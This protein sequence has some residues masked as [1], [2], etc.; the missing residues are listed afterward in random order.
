MSS[1]ARSAQRLSVLALLA[2]VAAMTAT[3]GGKESTSPPVPVA[4]EKLS[5]D[6][7]SGAAHEALGQPLVVKVL[8]ASGAGV[9][10]VRVVWVTAYPGGSDLD[11]TTTGQTG[12]AQLAV[13]LD[14]VVG[15]YT[16]TASAAQLSPVTFTITCTPGPAAKLV[17]L[18]QPSNVGALAAISPAVQ[19][20]VRDQWGNPVS[21]GAFPVQIWITSGTGA[22]GAT[23]SGSNIKSTAQG[24]VSYTDLSIDKP[25]TGYTLTALSAGLAGAWSSAFNVTPFP[26]APH[27]TFVAQP[28]T[29]KAGGVIAPAIQ[30]A[31]QGPYG[32]TDTTS[33]LT[34]TLA[35]TPGAGSAGARL[36]GTVSSAAVRGVAG[37][38]GLSVSYMGRGYTLTATASGASPAVSASFDVTGTATAIAMGVDHSCILASDGRVFCYGRNTYGQIGSANYSAIAAVVILGGP[39]AGLALGENHTCALVSGGA[40]SCWGSSVSG[41]L[42]DGTFSGWR[43]TPA[44]VSGGLAFGALD[45]T[46]H[47]TCGLTLAGQAWCWGENGS[48]QIGAGDS[49]ERDVPAAVSGGLTLSEI[50]V[51][52]Y[53]VCG[54]A[55]GGQAYCWGDNTSGEVGDSTWTGRVVPVR[56]AGSFVF[57]HLGHGLSHTCGLTPDGHA[58]CW[59]RNDTGQLGTGD[60]TARFAP[61]PVA[62]SVTFVQIVAGYYHSCGLTDAGTAYCWGANDDG[63]VGDG[64]TTSR[65]TPVPVAGALVFARLRA[66]A[67]ATCGVTTDGRAFCWGLNSSGQFGFT[68]SAPV[69][70]PTEVPLF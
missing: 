55:S 24:L 9:A 57:A 12:V 6:G 60:S 20:G 28:Q 4:V 58:Y 36:G 37:F 64:T 35:L 5:G 33:T 32:A 50:A 11:T 3:C 16:V 2:V 43:S 62:T 52:G 22:A 29:S 25:G 34:V 67:V 65:P 68:G 70:L 30:V 61:T 19:V 41:E 51:G 31:V 56:V 53:H 8:D 59:G 46:W 13:T 10:G 69:N 18:V 44:A 7:Q 49:V 48:G 38:P 66:N 40:A 42:G 21:A 14:T 54:L 63:E 1:A 47:T 45:A 27:L 17:F 26:S 39:V 23:L 15:S